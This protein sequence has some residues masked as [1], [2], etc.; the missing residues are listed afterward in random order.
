MLFTLDIEENNKKKL[1]VPYI[2]LC[3]L[4][5]HNKLLIYTENKHHGK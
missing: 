3:L 4:I 1:Q 2:Q 5:F